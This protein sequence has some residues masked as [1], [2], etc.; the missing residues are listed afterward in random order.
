M[1]R[2]KAVV[3]AKSSL[4]LAVAAATANDLVTGACLFLLVRALERYWEAR[5]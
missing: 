2:A 4:L 1:P 3:I 5:P